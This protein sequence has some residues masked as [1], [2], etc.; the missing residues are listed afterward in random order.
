[1][2]NQWGRSHRPRCQHCNYQCQTNG[3]NLIGPDVSAVTINAKSMGTILSAC[4][5]QQGTNYFSHHNQIEYIPTNL[6]LCIY[7]LQC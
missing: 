5:F 2:P 4:M 1:M 3:H 7:M 6:Y